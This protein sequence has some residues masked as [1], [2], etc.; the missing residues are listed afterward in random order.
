MS[1]TLLL[2]RRLWRC[3][4]KDSSTALWRR[5]FVSLDKRRVALPLLWRIGIEL[6]HSHAVIEMLERSVIA[7]H[8]TRGEANA[9]EGRVLA[10]TDASGRWRCDYADDGKSVKAQ[11]RIYV[12]PQNRIYGKATS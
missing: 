3:V 2:R 9:V 8:L 11:R 6:I 5:E 4:C 7:G 10:R 1:K 12:K